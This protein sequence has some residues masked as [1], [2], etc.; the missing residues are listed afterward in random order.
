M[1]VSL[2]FMRHLV[3]EDATA[4]NYPHAS[5]N[6]EN[7]RYKRLGNSY[8]WLSSIS[9]DEGIRPWFV[10]ILIGGGENQAA[11]HGKRK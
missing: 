10:N 2:R 1:E 3:R 11:K 4:L 9:E 7:C 5:H 6:D 8:H